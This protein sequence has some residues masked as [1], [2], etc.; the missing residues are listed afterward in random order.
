VADAPASAA[1]VFT[2]NKAVA[3]P[4]TVSREHLISSGGVASAIVVNAGCA[5]A[6]TGAAGLAAARDMAAAVSTALGCAP[7]R[8]LVSSTG[9]I[10]APLDITKI[11]AGIAD[12]HRELGTSGS[13]AAMR[14]IMTTDPFP[15]SKAV[16]VQ[17]PAG[18]FS[19]GGIAKGSGMIEP[20][21]AT[22]LGFLTTDARVA[23]DVLQRA[24]RRWTASAR[25]TTAPSC[26]PP[27]RPASAS[28]AM[29]TRR[30]STACARSRDI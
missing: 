18:T 24:L 15:K 6:C 4:V 5:N 25:P 28:R 10:G 13:D 19:I 27:A 1:A 23:P 26:W 29:T 3:A 22:M 21:M 20:R 16:S 17:T 7:D 30:C 2:T 11:R 8:V 14:A 12:A 9:V